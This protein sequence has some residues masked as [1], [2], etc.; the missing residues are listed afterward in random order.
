MIYKCIKKD[1]GENI[2]NDDLLNYILWSNGILTLKDYNELLLDETFPINDLIF[3][4]FATSII[5]IKEEKKR[6]VI[7]GDYDVDGVTATSIMYKFLHYLGINVNYIIPNRFTNGYGLK[8]ELVDKALSLGAEVIITVDN[9]ISAKEAI[10][11]AKSKNIKVIVTDHHSANEDFL[12]NGC[13]VV[14][15]NLYL[16]EDEFKEY[17]GAVLVYLLAKYFIE[18]KMVEKTNES[19]TLIEELKELAGVSTVS[20]VMPL[21]KGNRA[22]VKN[23]L[24]KIKNGTIINKGLRSVL[25]FMKKDNELFD[26][27]DIGFSLVPILNAPGRLEDATIVVKLLT[28]SDEER[29]NQYA[30]YSLFRNRFRKEFTNEA[31]DIVTQ[32]ELNSHSVNAIYIKN[33][34]EGIIGL[35]SGKVTESTSRPSFIFTNDKNG[36]MKGSGRSPLN[37]D[38]ISGFKRVIVSDEFKEG[39]II[40]YG[41]HKGAMG[42]TLKDESVVNKLQ[43]LMSLDY[44][45]HNTGELIKTFIPYDVRESNTNY[46]ED[47]YNKM[48]DLEPFGE[49]FEKGILGSVICPLGLTKSE[50]NYYSFYTTYKD[51]EGKSQKINFY[52][53]T[54][55]NDLLDEMIANPKEKLRNLLVLYTPSRNKFNDKLYYKGN[56]INIKEFIKK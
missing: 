53:F 47:Y 3:E 46:L 32:L 9:G 34:S 35:V 49:G 15:P 25:G 38:L 22:L 26:S 40:A 17:S 50:K 36:H 54:S 6:V 16:K 24:T 52:F 7:V 31:L 42:L 29:L 51:E 56:V 4:S 41:G 12:P 37:Y 13:L 5:K 33:L 20:D 2:L 45:T 10:D 18:N 43:E 48:E 14:N 28:E 23:L 44:E 1:L 11:Y 21:F 27:E 19:L 55:K 30:F 39:D 8:K